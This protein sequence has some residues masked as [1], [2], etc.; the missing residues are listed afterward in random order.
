[1]R[2]L[3]ISS[4]SVS[5]VQPTAMHMNKIEKLIYN[6]CDTPWIEHAFK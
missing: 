2:F 3:R 1:M 6:Q 5:I 4:Y